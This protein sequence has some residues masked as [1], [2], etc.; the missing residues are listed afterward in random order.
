MTTS[1]VLYNTQMVLA[2]INPSGLK[3][4]E[5]GSNIVVV[6]FGESK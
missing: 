4:I 2:I 6:P 1:Q 3:F 5:H